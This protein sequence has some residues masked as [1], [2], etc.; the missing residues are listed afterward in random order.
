[1]SE[2]FKELF[3]RPLVR[4]N[5]QP[6][7]RRIGR[8]CTTELKLGIDDLSYYLSIKKGRQRHTPCLPAHRGCAFQPVSTFDE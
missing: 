4:A 5:R 3:V 6:N 2:L 1:M 8:Y 7:L